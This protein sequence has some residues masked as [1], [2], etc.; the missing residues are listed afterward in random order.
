ME[1]FD[2]SGNTCSIC[3]RNNFETPPAPSPDVSPARTQRAKRVQTI[4]CTCNRDS[5]SSW[6]L[7]SVWSV[8][9]NDLQHYTNRVF[10]PSFHLTNSEAIPIA[11][12]FKN[13]M[14]LRNMVDLH[15]RLRYI[16][17]QL[18]V[19]RLSLWEP[20]HSFGLPLA[21][22]RTSG[23]SI[24]KKAMITALDEQVQRTLALE[25]LLELH[26]IP[27]RYYAAPAHLA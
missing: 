11:T 9:A 4:H 1:L 18:S 3:F 12:S 13:G 26:S 19:D 8:V 6:C 25:Q 7:L 16:E 27:N 2:K 17:P 24:Y 21:A 20:V 10:A 15:D 23:M 5:L 14:A 22:S